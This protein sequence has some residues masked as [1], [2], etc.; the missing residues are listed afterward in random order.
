MANGGIVNQ[1]GDLWFFGDRVDAKPVEI[2]P[3][4]Y[5]RTL[6][7]GANAMVCEITLPKGSVVALHHHRHEQ[8]GYLVSG[9]LSFTVNGVTH[10]VEAGGSW[11][12]PGDAPHT[13]TAL[14]DTIAIDIFSPVRDEYK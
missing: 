7:W 13:V 11:A 6:I 8:V 4:V 3:G 9:R 12:V 10:I 14:E 2:F 5:R 1:K